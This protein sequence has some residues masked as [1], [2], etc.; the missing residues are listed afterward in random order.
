MTSYSGVETQPS[1]SPDGNKVAFVWDGDR[2][3]NRDIYV[4][5]IGSAG[6]PMRL[7]TSTTAEANPA[8]SPDDRWIAF[9][10]EQP[11]QGSVA[12][13]LTP[14]IGGQERKLAEIS[15]FGSLSLP[16]PAGLCWT[17]DGTWLVLSER[18]ADGLMS[19]SA[20][21]ADTGERRRLT[22]YATTERAPAGVVLGDTFP[23]ISP[24]GRVLAFARGGIAGGDLH[25]MPLTEDLRPAGE[26]VKLTDQRYTSL[27]GVQWSADGRDIVFAAGAFHMQTLWRMS[28]SGKEPPKR[29]PFAVPDVLFPAIAPRA[30]RLAY[31]WRLQNVNLWRLDL[32]T[33]EH[34]AL[35]GSTHDSRHPQVL[36][37]WPQDRL[38]IESQ[39]EP[40]DLGL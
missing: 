29:L 33:G 40:G 25:L 35:V 24:D 26:P 28:A 22:V 38:S 4:M 14:P 3:D 20:I 30:S 5:Q 23:S 11:D 18:H 19:V 21:S 2:G 6:M 27:A 36:A 31:A 9:T 37:R 7:T 39:R 13:V 17:P 1:F 10:R 12:V 15:G 32:R 16:S 8:W 34:Q